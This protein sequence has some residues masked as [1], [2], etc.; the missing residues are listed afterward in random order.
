MRRNTL[1]GGAFARGGTNATA[2]P[3]W[4]RRAVL[5]EDDLDG[6]RSMTAA[7]HVKVRWPSRDN[8]VRPPRRF[9]FRGNGDAAA[10]IRVNRV[11]VVRVCD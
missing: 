7:S 10:T 11:R 8:V 1:F 4:R 5:D 2:P 3:Y 9:S 6:P